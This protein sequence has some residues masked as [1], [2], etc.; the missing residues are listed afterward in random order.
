MKISPLFPDAKERYFGWRYLLFQAVFLPYLLGQALNM[1]ALPL[2]DALANLISFS[3]NLTVVLICLRRFWLQACRAAL[4]NLPR[5]LLTA[6]GGL[7]A[8]WMLNHLM[9]LVIFALDPSFS[10]INDASISDIA[11]GNFPVM[12]FGTVVLVPI[13]EEALNRGCVFGSLRSRHPV[14]AYLVSM[15]VFSLIHIQ[16]YIGF[17]PPQTLLLCFLQYLPAGLVLAGAYDISGS[18]AAPILMH[19]AVNAI[20]IFALR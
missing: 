20:A 2:T 5:I 17:V 7:G 11:Q 4:A 10:N 18:I 19:T 12:A 1:L 14:A 6:L 3:I 15:A 13:A 16:G 9:S 8:Y